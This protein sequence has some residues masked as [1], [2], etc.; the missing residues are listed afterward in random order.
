MNKW[1][2]EIAILFK[3]VSQIFNENRSSGTLLQY[4]KHKPYF[5]QSF[6]SF[7]YKKGC[8]DERPDSMYLLK[9]LITSLILY[10]TNLLPQT[11]EL[12]TTSGTNLWQNLFFFNCHTFWLHGTYF[13]L[14]KMIYF[15]N[16][17]FFFNK[18]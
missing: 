1:F 17:D 5:C 4:E 7:L 13:I 2:F 16:Q 6:Q 18:R 14:T 8:S 3:I 11:F 10:L 9:F 15:D 12:I